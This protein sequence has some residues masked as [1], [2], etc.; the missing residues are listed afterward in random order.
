[1]NSVIMPTAVAHIQGENLDA[2][3]EPLAEFLRMV[4]AMLCRTR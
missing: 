3:L 2:R 4:I 1:M